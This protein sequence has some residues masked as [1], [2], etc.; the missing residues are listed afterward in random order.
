MFGGLESYIQMGCFLAMSSTRTNQ[1][2]SNFDDNGANR[3]PWRQEPNQ[4]GGVGEKR[5]SVANGLLKR[6]VPMA[7]LTALDD[8]EA[9][10]ARGVGDGWMA[11]EIRYFSPEGK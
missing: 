2:G 3:N 8:L 1:L 6:D 7:S 9:A 5:R 11:G 4:P 10:Q